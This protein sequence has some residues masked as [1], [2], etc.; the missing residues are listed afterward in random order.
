MPP[1]IRKFQN[2]LI[3]SILSICILQL[4]RITASSLDT[5]DSKTNLPAI[6]VLEIKDA[7]KIF[8][9]KDPDWW[10]KYSSAIIAMVTVF[11]AAILSYKISNKQA[12]IAKDQLELT[13]KQ[14]EENYRVAIAQVKANNISAARIEWIK[15]LRP[16]LAKLISGIEKIETELTEFDSEL[17]KIRDED[18]KAIDKLGDSYVAKLDPL[19]DETDHN[20]NQIKLFLNKNEEAH[21]HLVFIYET[22]ASNIFKKLDKEEIKTEVT[23]EQLIDTANV[24]LKNAW[25]QA[26]NIN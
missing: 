4:N 24:V 3:L 21:K 23:I 17:S 13:K 22:Y 10:D 8:A 15:E 2:K 18:Q 16:L 6:T 19:E 14:M 1:N 11:G 7:D 5:T 26:K 20:W 25:E 9:Q 12:N